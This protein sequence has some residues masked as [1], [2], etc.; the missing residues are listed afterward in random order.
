MIIS[1]HSVAKG[2]TDWQIL[3]KAQ[4]RIGVKSCVASV[5]NAFK[6]LVDSMMVN[7]IERCCIVCSDNNFDYGALTAGPVSHSS[8]NVDE[9]RS[10]LYT[11]C[12]ALIVATGSTTIHVD[13]KT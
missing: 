12:E 8:T 2:G 5:S 6:L 11:N 1:T 4:R 13:K 3:G 7:C 9:S 10:C